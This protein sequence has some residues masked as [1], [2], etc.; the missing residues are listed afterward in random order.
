MLLN[1]T[2]CLS[3]RKKKSIPD[4]IPDSQHCYNQVQAGPG[5]HATP[6][7]SLYD[8]IMGQQQQQGAGQSGGGGAFQRSRSLGREAANQ[9]QY[10]MPPRSV[11]F[12]RL[13][14]GSD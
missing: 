11:V 9:I 4:P 14:F 8:Q 10:N 12:F 6:S 2:L 5:L 7:Q 3:P 13:N 1:P